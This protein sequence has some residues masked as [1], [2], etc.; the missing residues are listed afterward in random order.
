MGGVPARRGNDFIA[1]WAH[2][3]LHFQRH[4]RV[5]IRDFEADQAQLN[6]AIRCEQSIEKRLALDRQLRHGGKTAA[7]AQLIGSERVNALAHSGSVL[8]VG[9]GFKQRKGLSQSNF[10][11]VSTTNGDVCSFTQTMDTDAS[12]R[13]QIGAM[14]IMGSNV[15]AAGNFVEIGG[16]VRDNLVALS[17]SD[18]SVRDR[19]PSPY[20]REY[21]NVFAIAAN[22][23]GSH[24]YLGG[25]FPHTEPRSPPYFAKAASP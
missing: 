14:R 22:S 13:D 15:I 9:R 17:G 2:E 25:R 5:A 10:A 21:N 11:V 12:A 3:L 24:L 1:V 7:I 20:G 16:L 23:V 18:L 4:S 8:Y 19:N 6:I